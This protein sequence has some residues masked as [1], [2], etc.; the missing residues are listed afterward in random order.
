M[1]VT[2]EK[3][4]DPLYKSDSN[5][6]YPIESFFSVDM[7]NGEQNFVLEQSGNGDVPLIAEGDRYRLQAPVSL[8]DEFLFAPNPDTASKP[9][10]LLISGPINIG[11]V[12]FGAGSAKLTDE[13]RIALAHVAQ[14]M[15]SSGLNGAFLVG[16]TDRS[17]NED[18]NLVLS[19]KRARVV[20]RYL[21]QS[22]ANLGVVGAQIT[23]ESMGEYQAIGMDG[24]SNKYDRKVSI[25]LH[26]G[27]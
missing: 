21:K 26:P 19:E 24:G 17:G 10:R 25:T 4:M 12:H 16:N 8:R 13:A 20:A 27:I 2:L 5:I 1:E 22:L 11:H 18:A 9:V 23:Y 14:Q 6:V 3:G 7:P 15:K